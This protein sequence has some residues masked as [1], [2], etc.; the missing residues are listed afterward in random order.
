MRTIKEMPT[1]KLCGELDATIARLQAD[2]AKL[3]ELLQRLVNNI[4]AGENTE[5]CIEECR[6]TLALNR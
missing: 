1:E 4:E 5:Q 3:R 2:R 6:R